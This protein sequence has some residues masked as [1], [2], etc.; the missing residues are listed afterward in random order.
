M[1]VESS[2][3]FLYTI[4]GFA[5]RFFLL[6]R[7][8]KL[9]FIKIK[10]KTHDGVPH[11]TLYYLG[12]TETLGYLKKFY[13]EEAEEETLAIVPFWRLREKLKRKCLSN[14][15]I[16]IEPNRLLDF[17][18][19][20]GGFQTFPWIKQ[21]VSI[22]DD[23]CGAR[24][25][26][27]D[28]VYGRKARQYQYHF[29]IRRDEETVSK[30]YHDLY[31]PYITCKYKKI[32]H[33]RSL[34]EFQVAVK[35]GFLLQVFDQDQW[36]S[37]SICTLKEKTIRVVAGGLAP[38][39]QYNLKRGAMSTC[40]YFLLKWAQGHGIET[41]DFMRS[42]ANRYDGL[43]EYKRKWGAHA[44]KDVWPHTSL[45]IFVPNGLPIPGILKKQLVWHEKE[46]VELE[47]MLNKINCCTGIFKNQCD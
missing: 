43:Y 33:V 39:Y 25:K 11:F 35:S 40:D 13:F 14:D 5:K 18:I 46:F 27:I 19:P 15:V 6:A 38:D 12:E 10:G 24:E 9:K 21:I 44:V 20:H 31:I 22:R 41:I 42:R 26:K 2:N 17:Y 1:F 4:S 29:K 3:Q 37:G 28:D 16:V 32:A 30:F 7:S 36:T 8:L 23:F 45:W 47:K 34:R